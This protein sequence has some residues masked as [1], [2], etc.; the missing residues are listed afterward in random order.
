MNSFLVFRPNRYGNL[1]MTH[2]YHEYAPVMNSFHVS[3]AKYRRDF[4][5]TGGEIVMTGGFFIETLLILSATQTDGI[6]KFYLTTE[7]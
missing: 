3:Q 7:H 2:H 1:F 6:F 5:M 4:F